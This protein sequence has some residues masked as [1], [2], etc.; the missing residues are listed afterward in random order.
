[1]SATQIVCLIGIM[2]MC[3]LIG[4]H[5]RKFKIPIMGTLIFKDDS[6]PKMVFKCQSFDELKDKNY[7][8]IKIESRQNQ[9]L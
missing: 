2:A 4:R 1:M 9:R 8:A 7:I 6:D 5:S 3:F